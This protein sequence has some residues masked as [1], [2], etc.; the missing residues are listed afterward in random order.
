M[1]EELLK[2]R[3]TFTAQP[4]DPFWTCAVKGCQIAYP[5]EVG[6]TKDREWKHV[7]ADFYTSDSPKT[8]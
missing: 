8:I 2:Y 4:N 6:I 5:H 7:W 1:E 3:T